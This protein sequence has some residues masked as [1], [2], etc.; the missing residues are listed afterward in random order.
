MPDPIVEVSL[1]AD[2]VIPAHLLTASEPWVARG[3]TKR[4]PLTSAAAKSTHSALNY[5]ESF[6]DGM[7]VRAIV[8]EA[9]HMARFFYNED[10]T[11][12][13]FYTI[14]TTLQRF[15]HQLIKYEND[16]KAPA[17]YVG[18][19]DITKLRPGM[20]TDNTLATELHEPTVSLWIGNRSRVSAH[21]DLPR[22]IACCV[23]GKR[24]FTLLPPDQA[25]NLY[26]GPWDMT[27]AG[28]PISLVDFVKPDYARFPNFRDAERNMLTVDLDVGDAVYIPSL[29]W[30]HV[31]GLSSINGLINFWWHESNNDEV[32]LINTLKSTSQLMESLPEDQRKA[33]KALFDCYVFGEDAEPVMLMK[34]RT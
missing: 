6:Y 29:W 24:R 26:V 11:G 21:F 30:H 17:I 34:N 33:M 14:E 15:F 23:A 13:N 27:P 2:Q 31:Q 4:W 12:F 28:Q 25:K 3:F 1:Y 8:A 20:S 19:V 7:M 22:N 32:S 18:S 10:M 5:L 16:P 9:R